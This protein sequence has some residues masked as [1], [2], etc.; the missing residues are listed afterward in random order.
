MNRRVLAI[1]LTLAAFA[2]T[3][4]P[5]NADERPPAKKPTITLD[6]AVS[7]MAEVRQPFRVAVTPPPKAEGV[8]AALQVQSS[9]GY[10]TQQ[11]L[12]LDSRGRASGLVVSNRAATRTY[13][14]VLLSARGRILATSTPVTVIWAPLTYTVALTC[15]QS[16]AP[17]RVDIPC[18]ITVA[19]TV[20]LDNVIAS[21]QVMGRTEWVPIEAVRVP[22]SGIIKTD[23]EGFEPGVGM[24]RVL[25]L[26]NAKLL[27]E[28]PTF[29]ITYSAP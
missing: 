9:T 19:P 10:V 22:P 8:I 14:A 21:L 24:Y 6:L 3:L 15:T 28:S 23:V 25:L 1:C 4:A 27:A 13:R 29:S 16:A 7:G 2:L 20:K 5:A 12:R 17:I 26:R 18:T 11:R